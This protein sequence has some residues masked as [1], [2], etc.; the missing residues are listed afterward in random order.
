VDT[1]VAPDGS[2]HFDSTLINTAGD[3]YASMP[4][5]HVAWAVWCVL[6]LYPVAR[7][8]ALRALAV[9]YPVLTTLVVVATGNHYFLDVIA[10]ALLSCVTWTAV[11]RIGPWLSVRAATRRADPERHPPGPAELPARGRP[12]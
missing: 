9:A 11:I 8:W 3:R 2:G 12:S 5:L 1:L 6:A 4:S 10:G 7:H